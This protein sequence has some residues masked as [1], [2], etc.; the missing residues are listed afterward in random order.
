MYVDMYRYLSPIKR[1]DDD[2]PR[3]TGRSLA[4]DVDVTYGVPTGASQGSSRFGRE[5]KKD[6]VH[7]RLL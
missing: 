2:G 1:E 5:K 6:F 4:F 7:S 3:S